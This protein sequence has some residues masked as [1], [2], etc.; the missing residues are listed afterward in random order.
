MNYLSTKKTAERWKI[1]ARRV[2]KYCNEGRIPGAKKLDWM[3]M[4]PSDANKPKD[5]R[6]RVNQTINNM[7]LYNFDENIFNYENQIDENKKKKNGIFYTDAE[8]VSL[9]YDNIKE[10]INIKSNILDPCC[11]LGSFIRGALNEGYKNIYG[12]DNDKDAIKECEKIFIKNTIHIN[13]YDTLSNSGKKVLD[14][15][16]NYDI[17]LIIGNPP[18]VP[19]RG[20]VSL[21]SDNK[22]SKKIENNGNNLFV[23]ALYRALEMIN[24]SGIISYIIPKNFLHVNSYNS[25]RKEILKEY[26]IMSIVD[27]GS[28]F[29]NVRGE[30]IVLTIKKQ[31]PNIGHTIEI[32]KIV[33]ESFISINKIKQNYFNNKII[34]FGSDEEIMIYEKLQKNYKNLGQ[35]CTGYIGRGKSK[36]QDDISGRNI[37]KFGFKNTDKKVPEVGNRIFIQNIYSAESG[38]IGSFAGNL[39][40]RET[41]TVITDGD[42]NICRYLLGILHSRLCNYY[43][44][45]YCFN[46]SKL[47]MHT[48]AKYMK[49]IPIIMD[50]GSKYYNLVIKI[51]NELENEV[52]L[53]NEWLEIYNNLNKL[54][55]KIY[56]LESDEISIIEGHM[57]KIQSKRWF[58]ESEKQ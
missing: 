53:S 58:A 21:K 42:E 6:K 14:T 45:K 11:G 22:F 31:E 52:Y 50:I 17:D 48:D 39:E 15:I 30:Q 27:I 41:V 55:Y 51:V 36:I 3:W 47:T 2:N 18:Y 56:G 5:K 54:V 9:M 37:I 26:K 20:N 29:K 25:L 8:M 49:K 28:Y 12:L 44:L 13:T 46:N 43:L 38:I 57:R 16:N 40:A 19:I 33:D 7:Y 23:V 34:L 24:E 4:I 32:K 10:Y 35:I 1:S